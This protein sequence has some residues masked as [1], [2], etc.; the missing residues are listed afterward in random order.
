METYLQVKEVSRDFRQTF[1]RVWVGEIGESCQLTWRYKKTSA[2]FTL[3]IVCY[4]V[5]EVKFAVV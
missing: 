3:K 1:F 2:L 4:Q 5:Y